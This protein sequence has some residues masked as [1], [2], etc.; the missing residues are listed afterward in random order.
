MLDGMRGPLVV[1]A[2]ALLGSWV[3]GCGSPSPFQSEEG[4]FWADDDADDDAADDDAGD[5]DADDD[6]AGDDDAGDDDAGDDDPCT[7]LDDHFEE[8][9]AA[10]EEEVLELTNQRRAQ[11]ASCGV[12]GSYGPAA[13]L[14]MN[15]E[16]RLAAR[17]HSWDMGEAGYFDHDS[18]GGPCGD[19]FVERIETAGYTGWMA[20]GENIAA[21]QTS[22]QQVVS[23]W[24][25]SDGHCA[26]IMEP[27]FT[28]IGIGYAHVPG[29]YYSTYWTQ[30]FGG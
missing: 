16:L 27:S 12:Y 22:A 29:S 30:D 5:D 11:G 25:S 18:P 4:E 3:P 24:M 9:W 10:F 19:D 6:D 13:A 23:G 20:A 2:A 17:R 8:A 26:N 1:A 28:E 21:A 15:H 7:A 14:A